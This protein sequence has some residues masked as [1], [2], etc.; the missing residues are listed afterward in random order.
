MDSSATGTGSMEG[1]K[2]CLG[3]IRQKQ[4]LKRQM[5]RE[6]ANQTNKAHRLIRRKKKKGE[7][8]RRQAPGSYP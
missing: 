4:R 3:L 8:Y 5:N 1:D 6:R 2:P 7:K